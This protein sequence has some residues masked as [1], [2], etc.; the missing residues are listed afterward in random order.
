MLNK[1]EEPGV[2]NEGRRGL[3]KEE[4]KSDARGKKNKPNE[5]IGKKGSGFDR[6]G[7]VSVLFF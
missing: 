6:R 1:P 2:E 4:V 5:W 7:S 3:E